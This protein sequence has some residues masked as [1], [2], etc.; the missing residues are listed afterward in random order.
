M[1]NSQTYSLN[2][3][4][5]IFKNKGKQAAIKEITQLYNQGVCKPISPD[6][7]TRQY[8]QTGKV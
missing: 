4:L 3:G 8:H 1:C 6:N 7:I 2:K 5:H